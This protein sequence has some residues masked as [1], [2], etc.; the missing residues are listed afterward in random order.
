MSRLSRY[1]VKLFSAEALSFLIVAIF[2]VY[3]TQTLRLFDL[4][5]AKGQDMLTLL[6]QSLLTT[7]PL[8]LTITYICMGI[9]LV[10]G[11][12]TLQSTRELH[13]IHASGRTGAIWQAVIVFIGAGLIF[14]G[15][16]AHWVEPLAGKTYARWQ[17][18]VAADLVGR[19]LSPHRFSEVTPGLVV[20]IG[21]RERDGTITNF[22]AHDTRDPDSARTYVA[23]SAVIVISDDGYNVRLRNGAVQYLR[24]GDDFTEIG[25]S[26]YEV[27]LDRPRGVNGS[28]T[29]FS[30][31]TT[32]QI[33]GAVMDGET[34]RRAW[35]RIHE[36]FAD[37]A[38]VLA[39]CL[40]A[41]A[42]AAFPH[43]RRTNHR[44]PAEVVVLVLGLSDRVIVSVAEDT[45]GPD[46]KYTGAVLLLCLAL[47]LTAAKLFGQRLMLMRRR[48]A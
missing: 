20:I 36:R 38:R 47:V 39:L 26:Q 11:L 42:M 48:P 3:I 28:A 12:R 17:E 9:G 45:L 5:T 8:T 43:G 14:T 33:I 16:L 37:M 4:V 1:L 2:L 18:Q 46:G 22:F 10:R 13:T 44:I 15:L 24:E 40:V 30:E 21:G 19:A 25:F 6:G 7:P 31:Q 41:A 35:A 32:P 23:D 34:D 29:D 27:G